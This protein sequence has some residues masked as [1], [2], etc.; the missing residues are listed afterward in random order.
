M[1]NPVTGTALSSFVQS[2]CFQP[3]YLL[4]FSMCKYFLN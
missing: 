3:F 4:L 1:T 2:E